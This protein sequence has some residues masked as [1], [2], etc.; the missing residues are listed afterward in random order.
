MD[1]A[2]SLEK[3]N[4]TIIKIVWGKSVAFMIW[5]ICNDLPHVLT[6][7]LLVVHTMWKD[8]LSPCPLTTNESMYM[9]SLS[10]LTAALFLYLSVL[11]ETW[12]WFSWATAS[13]CRAGAIYWVKRKAAQGGCDGA[14]K[15]S[16]PAVSEES[17]YARGKALNLFVS[18]SPICK[19]E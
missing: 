18:P 6:R 10:R 11:V 9:K 3:L 12:P 4:Y 19:T 17:Q 5:G 13:F 7:G 14:V 1:S 2:K 16:A 8:M 15:P